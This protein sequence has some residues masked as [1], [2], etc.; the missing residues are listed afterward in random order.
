VKNKIY[1]ISLILSFLVVLSHEMIFHHHHEP[2]AEVLFDCH[3][4]ND[5]TCEKNEESCSTEEHNHHF[6]LHHH[7]LATSD[8]ISAKSNIQ[9]SNPIHKISLLFGVSNI[10]QPDFFE[11]PC[12]TILRFKDKPFLI[13]SNYYPAAVALRGPPAIV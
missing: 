7:I 5:S 3:S 13:S 8:F 9:K 4:P 10:F 1:A 11:P 6:P 12:L 2:I